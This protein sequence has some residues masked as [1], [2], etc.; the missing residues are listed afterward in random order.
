M[1]C[2]DVL[3][4]GRRIV[5]ELR[6][7]GYSALSKGAFGVAAKLER[8]LESLDIALLPSE[9][10]S[11]VGLNGEDDREHGVIGCWNGFGLPLSHRIIRTPEEVSFGGT[12]ILPRKAT[13]K[14]S[15]VPLSQPA[16]C[17]LFGQKHIVT[18]LACAA[19]F[20]WAV[21]LTG[22]PGVGTSSALMGRGRL[23]K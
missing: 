1:S 10:R 15:R 8:E 3:R 2:R 20:H 19:A 23:F 5:K 6:S 11:S 14:P 16:A 9:E 22:P 18:R 7:V 4:A 13:S 12:I 21:L 17:G